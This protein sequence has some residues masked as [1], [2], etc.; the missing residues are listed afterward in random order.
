MDN[1]KSSISNSNCLLNIPDSPRSSPPSS[2]MAF[3]DTKKFPIPEP[4][5]TFRI[6]PP[7]GLLSRLQAFL[8]QIAEANKKLQ[9]DVAQDPHKLDIENV[10]EEEQYIEMDLGLGVFDMKPKKEDPEG[11]IIGRRPDEQQQQEEEELEGLDGGGDA[12]DL[13]SRIIIKPSSIARR[14]RGAKPPR[15]EM[16]EDP[17][18]SS[19]DEDTSSANDSESESGSSPESASGSDS[20]SDSDA[21]SDVVMGD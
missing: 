14:Q 12:D 9:A 3:L 2:P 13:G 7:S 19:E 20:G 1:T 17:L 4:P 8:P 6:E 11:I 10:N 5:K 21:D 15:I 18:H 16:L